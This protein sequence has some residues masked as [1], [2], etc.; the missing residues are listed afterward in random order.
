MFEATGGKVEVH[1]KARGRYELPR[2]PSGLLIHPFFQS[3]RPPLE[4]ARQRQHIT[5]N[6]TVAQAAVCGH[7][8]AGTHAADGNVLRLRAD[9]VI[10]PH[11]R[12]QFL[13]SEIGK[14]LRATQLSISFT[15]L[16]D[17]HGHEGWNL[18]TG[19][20]VIEN[21]RDG[22]VGRR[23]AVALTVEK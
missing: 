14:R 20:Q 3:A 4:A 17:E 23:I 21:D 11:P 18:S 6:F 16:V 15:G 10:L 7:S 22:H 13:G 8:P 19:D 2:Q 12:D 1:W 5:K 9:P